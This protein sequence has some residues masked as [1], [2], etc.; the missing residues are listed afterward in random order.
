MRPVNPVCIVALVVALLATAAPARAGLELQSLQTPTLRVVY[1]DPAHA[2]ILPHLARCYENS[3]S[4]FKRN[5]GY[6]PGEEVTIL[7]QDFDDYGYAGTSTIPNN[8]ITLGIEPFE[9]VYETCPTNERFN[10]VMSHELF[11]VVASEKA[12]HTDRVFRSLFRGKVLADANNPESMIYSYLCSPRRFAPRWYHEGIAV[13]METWMAGGIGRSLGGYDEMAFRAMVR[14]GRY[15]YDVVGL[16]SEGT[17]SDFQIGQNSYLYGTRFVSYLAAQYS[18]EK[19]MTWVNRTDSSDAYY[20]SQF[21]RV[22]GRSLDD[23]WERWIGFEHDWQEQNLATVAEYPLTPARVVSK[24]GLGSVS[25]GFVDG[26]TGKLLVAV[27]YPGEYAHVAAIDMKTG[28][29]ENVHEVKTPA[30]YYV[31]SLAFDEAGRRLFYTTNNG[32]HWRDLNA[33]DLD[34]RKATRLITDCRIG[35]LAFS[36]ADS[37]LWGVQHHNGIS[38]LVRISPP[39]NAWKCILPLMDL[40]YG[41]DIFDLDVAP[42]GAHVTASMLEINGSVK[43]VEF[44][45]A[46]MLKGGGAYRVLHEFDKTAPANFV[47]SADGTH[48]YGTAYQTGVSNVFRWDFARESMECVTN[49]DIGYFRPIPM[50]DS[51]VVFT[52]S[53]TGFRPAVIADTTLT[54][55]NAVQYLGNEVVNRHPELRDWKLGSPREINLDS[56][57]TYRGVYHN[58][59]SITAAS[60]YPVVE[61]YKAYTSVG[62]RWNFMDPLGVHGGDAVI[63]VSPESPDDEMVHAKLQFRHF[64]WTLKGAYN[65]ADFYDFFGPTKVSRKGHGV[66]LERSDV[67]IADKPRF[68]EYTVNVAWYG[69]LERLP[70]NQNVLATF[71]EYGAATASLDYRRLQRTIGGVDDEKGIRWALG[72]EA[73]LVN[74]DFYGKGT[75]ELDVG[76]PTPI[77]HSSIW[78]RG[79]GGYSRGDREDSFASFYFGGFGNNYVDHQEV[80]RYRDYDRFPGVD[81]DEI[82]GTSFTR[83]M[84]E[85]TLPPVKFRRIGFPRLY[86]TYARAALFTTGLATNLDDDVF[87]REAIN[88]G[89]QVDFRLVIFSALESTLSIGGAAAK[90]E[91]RDTETEFMI[92]LKIM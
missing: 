65:R 32:K 70:Y 31:T 50:G 44:D 26:N 41:R 21:R 77:D 54:D 47:Y 62:V 15:F 87:R 8:Y 75:A 16:E 53:G 25:R 2:Y 33:I 20:A 80:K 52:Y 38:T 27:N 29:M 74:E 84:A 36:R 76:V 12:S 19:V 83:L 92:S 34:T 23:E 64:P 39:Y 71:D 37:T 5:L 88:W 82:G 18:P 10:W 6:V 73:N 48:L 67:I 51:L 13:F 45:V 4:Y 55:V 68:L 59:R 49:T 81:I 17:T 40:T 63:G 86:C 22:F 1:Y 60:L 58:F 14:D 35:D 79:A 3:Y 85:W 91:G 61:A 28:D 11:H 56:L 30:L 66:L 78:L 57:T 24:Q 42:D 90:E 43:L 7:L 72:L 69:G 9:Y 89:G 46:D